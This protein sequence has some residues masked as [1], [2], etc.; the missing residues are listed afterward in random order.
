MLDDG[1]RLLAGLHA[2]RAE[3]ARDLARLNLAAVAAHA[4]RSPGSKRP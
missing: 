1:R 4:Y 2:I 3:L